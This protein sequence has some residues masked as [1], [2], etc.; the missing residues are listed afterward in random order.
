MTVRTAYITS[1]NQRHALTAWFAPCAACS[2]SHR[3]RIYFF[4]ISVG[5][6]GCNTIINKIYLMNSYLWHVWVTAKSFPSKNIAFTTKQSHINAVFLFVKTNRLYFT[7]VLKQ[8]SCV[9]REYVARTAQSTHVL[10]VRSDWVHFSKGENLL[11]F[12][13]ITKLINT[14]WVINAE[15]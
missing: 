13:K 7:P 2:N 3:N 6:A 14:F 10:H 9:H 11:L 5:L 8:T 1:R 15:N 12:N 4:S